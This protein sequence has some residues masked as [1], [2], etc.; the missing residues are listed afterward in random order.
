MK[1]FLTCVFLIAITG[2]FLIGADFP[3]KIDA[4]FHLDP[5]DL[6]PAELPKG[7]RQRLL[8]DPD[9]I[10]KGEDGKLAKTLQ[11]LMLDLNEDKEPEYMVWDPASY[12]GGSVIHLFSSA[13]SGFKPIGAIQG[14]YYLA[15]AVNGYYQIVY[16][17]RAGG[18]TYER[19]LATY[20]NGAYM[21]TH[22]AEFRF[23]D[24]DNIVYKKDLP[25][26]KN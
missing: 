25:A 26:G 21:D 20:K 7:L 8:D 6:T 11:V 18:G 4:D 17:A 9:G 23:D 19:R 3:P 12:T 2:H 5:T 24:N 13:D 22:A 16:T 10:F 15:K 1:S 14:E